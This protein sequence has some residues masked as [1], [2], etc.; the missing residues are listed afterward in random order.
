MLKAYGRFYACGEIYEGWFDVDTISKCVNFE[1]LEFRCVKFL[2]PVKPEKIICV[3]LNYIDH[4][5]ELK[6]EIPDEP[7]IFLKPPSSLI[8]DGDSIVIPDLPDGLNRVDYEG[9]LAIVISKKCRS[10]SRENFEEFVLGY[11]CFNDV[12]ARDIQ[13]KDGQWTRAKSFDTFA[14]LGPY[15][16]NV[17]PSDL[18]IVT[19][20][21]GKVVQKSRTSNLIFDVGYLVEFIS[22]VMTLKKGD[23][24]ATGTPA[25]VGAIKR[26]D[27]VEVEI[28]KIGT[29]EN[30]VI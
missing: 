12:T 27:I 8:G 15:I 7:V 30:K 6:M 18:Q 23:V 28:E 29:L 11:T 22:S 17:D 24:I 19:R 21:N 16:V 4:A 26:G 9:E 2:P 1:G 3:G 10:I 14:S 13:K 25:G 20:L 5:K